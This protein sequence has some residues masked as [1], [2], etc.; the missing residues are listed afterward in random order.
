MNSTGNQLFNLIIIQDISGS[1]CSHIV[2]VVVIVIVVVVI[3]VVIVV[4]VEVVVICYSYDCDEERSEEGEEAE[5]KGQSLM[6]QSPSWP[7]EYVEDVIAAFLL[8]VAVP[9]LPRCRS[10]SVKRE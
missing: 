9:A 2:V 4:V 5:N 10:A 1:A 6:C 7:P 8:L 3:V